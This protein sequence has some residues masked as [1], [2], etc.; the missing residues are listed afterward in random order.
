MVERLKLSA[1]MV[2]ANAGLQSDRVRRRV[3][4]KY[5]DLPLPGGG[6]ITSGVKG[7]TIMGTLSPI[8]VSR[9]VKIEK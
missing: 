6:L 7:R 3:I 1:Q 2:R 8:K 9:R 4:K 5:N